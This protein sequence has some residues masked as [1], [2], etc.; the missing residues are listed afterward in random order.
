MSKKKNKGHTMK[1]K[2]TTKERKALN[3]LKLV[4]GKNQDNS[5]NLLNTNQDYKKAG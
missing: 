4:E 5:G 2:L 3:H 1:K